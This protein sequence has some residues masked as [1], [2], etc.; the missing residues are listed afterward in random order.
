MAVHAISTEQSY[1]ELQCEN[2]AWLETQSRS[3][4]VW[5]HSSW[6]ISWSTH[7]SATF[8]VLKICKCGAKQHQWSEAHRNCNEN[9]NLTQRNIFHNFRGSGIGLLKDLE[10]WHR[11]PYAVNDSMRCGRLRGSPR[12]RTWKWRI[13]ETRGRKRAR[14]GPMPSLRHCTSLVRNFFKRWFVRLYEG[15]QCFFCCS[16]WDIVASTRVPYFSYHWNCYYYTTYLA[17]AWLFLWGGVSG[18][19]STR[20]PCGRETLG[21]GEQALT[22]GYGEIIWILRS[23]IWRYWAKGSR[24][25]SWCGRRYSRW[26]ILG[27]YCVQGLRFLVN[28]STCSSTCTWVIMRQAKLR[29]LRI[30]GGK[31]PV[32]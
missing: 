11:R 21:E 9:P 23:E 16:T 18:D 27:Q 10:P 22:R 31:I 29:S 15:G 3:H 17:R 14:F 25:R 4:G 1:R 5:H 30:I 28:L 24:P 19:T 8:Q 32:I 2:R 20:D 12:T 26:K 6:C 7:Q 13:N